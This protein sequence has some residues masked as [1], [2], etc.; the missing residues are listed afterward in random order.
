MSRVILKPANHSTPTLHLP[1][2]VGAEPCGA[3]FHKFE[4]TPMNANAGKYKMLMG[5]GKRTTL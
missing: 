4:R 1:C 3:M 5:M 2:Y